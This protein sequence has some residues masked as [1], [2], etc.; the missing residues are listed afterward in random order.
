MK[1]KLFYTHDACPIEPK[2]TWVE[3]HR[4]QVSDCSLEQLM[5]DLPENVSK[6]DIYLSIETEDGY[7]GE[8]HPRAYV[9]WNETLTLSDAEYKKLYDKYVL[10]LKKYKDKVNKKAAKSVKKQKVSKKQC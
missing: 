6:K 10:E 9:E 7:Y 2:N 5:E 8:T 4:R 1:P 3:S